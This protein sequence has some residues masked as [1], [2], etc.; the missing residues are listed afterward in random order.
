EANASSIRGGASLPDFYDE[1]VRSHRWGAYAQDRMTMGARLSAEAGLRF[2]QSSLTKDVEKE[3]RVSLLFRVGETSRW[4]A[5][6]GSHSQSP[7]IE[8]LLQSD[9]FLDLSALGLGNEH[10]RHLTFGFE[11][12]FAGL[13]LKTEA[14]YKN[15]RDLIVGAL[16]T[17]AEFETRLSRYDFPA[18]FEA[19]IPRGRL[20]TTAPEN[21]ASGRAYGAE[22]VATRPRQRA[23]QRLSGWASYSFGKATREAYGLTLPF[24]YDR[25]HAV[26]IVGQLNASEKIDIGFTLRASSG[27]PRT[28]AVGVRVVPKKDSLDTDRDGNTTELIPERDGSGLPV[29]TADYGSVT[30]LLRARYPRFTRLDLRVNW[31]PRG[32]RSRWLFY[33]EFINA[34]NRQNVGQYEATL[35]TVSGGDRPR[36]EETKAASLPFLPTFGVRFRF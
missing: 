30:N 25:R 4:R 8:K 5:A 34:T 14:Y 22:I 13:T 18:A 19:S 3:P 35:R 24:E 10:S 28:K 1:K 17:D 9:Y 26:S 21:D 12:D 6:Y 31:R 23:G 20:I 16:E 33:L 27:F 7:G 32:D 29:Y 2:S 11:K 36:I 15:F